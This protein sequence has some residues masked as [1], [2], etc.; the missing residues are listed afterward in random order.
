VIAGAYLIKK[1][2]L[3]EKNVPPF[4]KHFADRPADL[5]PFQRINGPLK[6]PYIAIEFAANM[7][8]GQQDYELIE[9][10]SPEET[11]DKE[12]PKGISERDPTFF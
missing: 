11:M 5:H 8:L 9:V 2:G 7:G 10:L 6:D 1:E 3:I 4:L 12:P